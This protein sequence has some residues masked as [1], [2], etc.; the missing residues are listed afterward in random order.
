MAIATDQRLEIQDLN[1]HP[2]IIPLKL[3][4]ARIIDSYIK[5][6]HIIDL[7]DIFNTIRKISENVDSLQKLDKLGSIKQITLLKFKTLESTFYEIYP[8][9]TS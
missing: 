3:G 5:Y 9:K 7:E 4:N 8:F 1:N 6:I 2:G